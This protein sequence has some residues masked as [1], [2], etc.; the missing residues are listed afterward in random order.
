MVKL[1][2]GAAELRS[3]RNA[4]DGGAVDEGVPALVL[5]IGDATTEI[6]RSMAAICLPVLAFLRDKNCGF[7]SSMNDSRS[8]PS[9]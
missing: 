5:G 4:G 7:I 3:T 2:V 1:G 9:S 8:G 6:R